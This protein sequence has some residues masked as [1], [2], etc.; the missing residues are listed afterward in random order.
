MHAELILISHF[1]L[2]FSLRA[3]CIDCLRTGSAM[4]R[5]R[6]CISRPPQQHNRSNVRNIY[7]YIYVY[8]TTV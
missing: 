4:H 7:I 8:L 2:I 1:K 5:D 6:A 3:K